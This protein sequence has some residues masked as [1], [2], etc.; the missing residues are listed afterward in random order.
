MQQIM[1]ATPAHLASPSVR[2][3]DGINYDCTAY[4]KVHAYI[5]RSSLRTKNNTL[6]KKLGR[7]PK[8]IRRTSYII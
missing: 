4:K 3:E 1:I 7:R 2:I 6:G 8:E 5:S